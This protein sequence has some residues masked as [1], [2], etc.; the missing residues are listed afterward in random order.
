YHLYGLTGLLQP[1]ARVCIAGQPKPEMVQAFIG[2]RIPAQKLAEMTV[3]YV[4][5]AAD[6]LSLLDKIIDK[7]AV[8]LDDIAGFARLL[9]AQNMLPEF[10]YLVAAGFD[11]HK[12]NQLLLRD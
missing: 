9:A 1:I 2:S 8:R 10:D 12:D 7:D 5:D 6:R 3:E 4:G 11:L